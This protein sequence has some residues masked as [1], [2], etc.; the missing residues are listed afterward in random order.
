[1]RKSVY[2]SK[3]CN[4]NFQKKKSIHLRVL[5]YLPSKSLALYFFKFSIV[6]KFIFERCSSLLND[7]CWN[8][9][10][11][12]INA[13]QKNYTVYT[14]CSQSLAL[15]AMYFRIIWVKQKMFSQEYLLRDFVINSESDFINTPQNESTDKTKTLPNSL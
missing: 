1:M 14:A 12:S 3:P 8:Y 10:L 6:V 15:L 5:L 2:F 13:I 9:K 11:T 4:T 7:Y